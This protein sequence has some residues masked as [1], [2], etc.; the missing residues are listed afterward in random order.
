MTPHTENGSTGPLPEASLP[1]PAGILADLLPSA[2]HEETHLS[3]VFITEDD[4]YK[5]KKPLKLSFCDFSTLE[6]RRLACLKEIEVNQALAGELYRG[7]LPITSE[8]GAYRIGG[9]GE[10]IDWLV[11]MSPFRADDRADIAL[12]Q[13]RLSALALRDFVTRLFLHH[14]QTPHIGDPGWP[15]HLLGLTDDLAAN[16]LGASA[17]PERTRNVEQWRQALR[18]RIIENRDLLEQRGRDA[19]LT[20]CHGD[21]HLKNLCFWQ[22]R[23]V[24]Y[25]ALEF[26][27]SLVRIDRLYDTAFL[28]ADLWH[29]GFQ[30]HAN[31][32]MNRYLGLSGDYDSVQLMPVYGALRA[33]IRG[34]TAQLSGQPGIAE[35]YLA[36]SS[37]FLAPAPGT[38]PFLIAGRSG[39]GKSTL[40]AS[41]APRLA[42]PPGA[43]HIRSD[44]LRKRRAGRLPED[45]L[46]DEAYGA[47]ENRAVYDACLK[48]AQGLKD[49]WPVILDIA[50]AGKG[51]EDL[52]P[53]D[54]LSPV[55]IWLTAP[56]DILRLRIAGRREDASDATIGV[57]ESQRTSPPGD[58]WHMIDASGSPDE[59]LTAILKI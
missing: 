45:Q 18:L 41:L 48:T 59:T 30:A 2:R 28:I 13:G 10:P 33:A 43:L 15:D 36:T 57:M 23:L 54:R 37:T 1:D 38:R 55:K 3:H 12:R 5:L 47:T 44:V 35:D 49:R 29:H 39:T 22:D 21:L 7:I 34:M 9:T 19:I 32:V 14:K 20:R 26:D 31:L 50:L 6:K 8:N 17:P 51:A 11:H 46:P 56:E 53:L 27:E 58:G 4:V 25:D 16:L 24:A 52:T 42:P 40:A